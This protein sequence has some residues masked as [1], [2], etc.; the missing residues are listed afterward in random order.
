MKERAL[1]VL[2][3]SIITIL[4]QVIDIIIHVATDQVEPIRITS[5]IIIMVWLGIVA[6]GWFAN[7]KRQLAYSAVGLYSILNLSFLA[8]EGFGESRV[9]R[10]VLFNLVGLTFVFSMGVTAFWFE[11]D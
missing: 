9:L 10:A 4:I 11:Q 5:N 7:W 2:I 3:F 8:T 1:I 6:S